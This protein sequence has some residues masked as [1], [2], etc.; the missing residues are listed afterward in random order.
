MQRR[1][2]FLLGLSAWI[3]SLAGPTVHALAASSAARAAGASAQVPAPVS[4][5]SIDSCAAAGLIAVTATAPEG[6]A[7]ERCATLARSAGAAAVVPCCNVGTVV[8]SIQAPSANGPSQAPA[9]TIDTYAGGGGNGRATNLSMQPSAVVMHDGALYIADGRWNVVRRLDLQTGIVTTVAGNGLAGNG[10]N[11]Y[12]PTAADEMDGIPALKAQLVGPVDIAFDPQGNLYIDDFGSSRIRKVDSQ[13]IITTVAGTGAEGYAGDHGPAT[14]AALNLPEGIAFDAAGD[15]YIA[16]TCNQVIRKV[17]TTGTITTV[18]GSGAGGTQLCFQTTGGGYGGD[19]GAATAAQ[20]NFPAAVAVDASGNIF[21]SDFYNYRVRRVDALTGV[22]TTYAGTGTLGY[23]G[24]GGAA[25]QA[26][27]GDPFHMSVDAQGNL[28]FAD[29]SN[30]R[31]REVTAASP[32]LISTVAGDGVK[33]FAGDDGPATAAELVFPSGV[34][35]DGSGGFFIADGEDV[36][37]SGPILSLRVRHVDAAGTITSV[38]GDGSFFYGGDGGAATSAQF[39]WTTSV[40]VHGCEAYITEAA[41]GFDPFHARVRK[42]GCDGVVT[43]IAGTGVA[44]YAGDGGPATAAELNTPSDVV[45]DAADDVYIADSGNNRVRR[46]DPSGTITTVAGSGAAG[47]GGDG[48]PASAAQLNDASGL[49]LDPS[50]GL[51]IADSANYRIREVSPSGAIRTVAGSGTFGS[52]GDNGPATAADIGFVVSIA[53]DSHGNLYIADADN[54]E[55]RK[56]DTGGTITTVAGNGLPMCGN[57]PCPTG[58]GGPATL[59][60]LNYPTGVAVDSSGD[61]LIADS[62]DNRIR[63]VDS[64]GTIST[65]AGDGSKAYGGDAG[66]A[67]S[68]QLNFPDGVAVDASGNV[69]AADFANYRIRMVSS[70]V[71]APAGVPESPLPPIGIATAL[72]V[73]TLVLRRR[74]RA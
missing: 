15:L 18:A 3:G 51:L 44:G 29:D 35:V 12:S 8:T 7:A 13:G 62:F 56:V 41:L 23:S 57:T 36:P 61:I 31:I 30:H 42:V 39:F 21:I 14:L 28:L 50:G 47:F 64:S 40:A 68:A 10:V 34:G 72:I 55:I 49:A 67:T 17:D 27:I 53:T 73:V 11:G 26:E 33:G 54:D 1:L 37:L 66:P 24:D 25:D 74:R 5:P 20:L 16:D 2:V 63:K 60:N 69:F 65:L 70:G 19:G 48:G 4:S 9:G 46:V 45:A 59:A 71:A 38:A 52:S 43:T 32:H 58:D 22:M 6:A